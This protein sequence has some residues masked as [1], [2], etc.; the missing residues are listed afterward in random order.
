VKLDLE[1]VETP[2]F[3]IDLGAL[4]RNCELLARVQRES[5]AK[6]LLALKGFAAWST[7]SL[8]RRFLSGTTA[9]GPFEARL[10]REEFGG[11]VHAY[12]PAFSDRD[13]DECLSLC[14]H[15]VFNSFTQW[16]RYRERCLAAAADSPIQFGLRVNPE[17]SEVKVALYD[18]C[19]PGS[20]LGIRRAEFEGQDLSGLSGLHLH[21]LCEL[22][23]DALERTLAV[24]EANWKSLLPS[25]DWVNFGGG[26]HITRPGYDVERLVRLV[27]DF[28]SRYGLDVY[29]EPGEAIALDAGV[30]TASV[31]DIVH[32]DGAI[33]VLDVSATAHMPDVLEMPY[34]PEIE[35][36]GEPGKF[37]HEYRLGGVTCLAGDEIGRYSF[38][39]PLAVGDKLV[40]RDMAI[41]TMVKTTMFN[42]V[43]HPSI[44]LLDPKTGRLD[45]VRRFGYEDYKGRL[46]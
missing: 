37:P 9:S 1:A 30:L 36:A 12:A 14:D 32:N 13:I 6:V 44:A 7:F 4:E 43:R 34:Q 22:D 26:H 39:R 19:R 46:S 2:A 27:R 17:H 40:F 3:V 28:R 20:R 23:S 45:V 18:P 5:G 38:P 21:T 29:L 24:F 8:L 10:G 35:G 15:V 16:Q 11:E 25:L 41:Y 33:A 31:L 42:G